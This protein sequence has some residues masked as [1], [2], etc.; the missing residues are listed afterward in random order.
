MDYTQEK[1]DDV[2]VEVVNI[3]R[4]TLGEATEFK[5]VLYY[6]IARGCTKLIVDLS[7]CEFIDSTFLGAL[8][9]SLKRVTELGG[10]L[11]LIGFHPAV[12]SM[13]HLTRMDRVFEVFKTKDDA[14]K[15]YKTEISHKHL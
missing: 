5:E 1:Y 10:D 11:R 8:V 9:V 12:N 15:S 7:D 3:T 14:I 13:F 2:I 6:D 4:A